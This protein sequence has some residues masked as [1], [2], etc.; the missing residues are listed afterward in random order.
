LGFVLHP[1]SRTHFFI[2]NANPACSCVYICKFQFRP[3]HPPSRRLSN[4]AAALW[5]LSSTT[6]ERGCRVEV[7]R[8]VDPITDGQIRIGRLLLGDLI[9]TVRSDQTI[10]GDLSCIELGPLILD[11]KGVM[12][13]QFV[14]YLEQI[15]ALVSN[16]AATIWPYPF[17]DAFCK[18]TPMVF[19]FQPAVHL[20]CRLCLRIFC[21]RA[22]GLPEIWRPVQSLF[23]M[24]KWISKFILNTKTIPWTYLI[25]RKFICSPNWSIPISKI[26]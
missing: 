8:A 22:P 21:A 2:T 16:R 18:R 7:V 24:N 13:Y 3:I 20:E 10:P 11:P 15:R 17:A 26:L 14:K 19:R 4:G 5:F 12:L 1:L 6:G 23:K 9:R 25:H